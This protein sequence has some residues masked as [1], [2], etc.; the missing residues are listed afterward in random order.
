MSQGVRMFSMG[1]GDDRQVEVGM[2]HTT[3]TRFRTRMAVLALTLAY[4]VPAAYGAT[5]EPH[6]LAH[7]PGTGAVCESP[8]CGS[9]DGGESCT[10]CRVWDY[11]RAG[12][13]VEAVSFESRIVENGVVLRVTA[14]DPQVQQ[15]LWTICVAR[16]HILELLRQGGRV[17]LCAA[18][19]ANVQ[20]FAEVEIG[21]SRLANGVL[22]MYTSSDSDIVDALHTM[23]LV[24]S[25]LPL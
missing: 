7:D 4:A 17:P 5:L 14:D 9:T 12:L 8:R 6:A 15:L 21:T 25:D 2:F 22:L 19:Q 13:D 18:C 16:H 11:A 3:H 23:V 1:G 24:H 20:A 10:A